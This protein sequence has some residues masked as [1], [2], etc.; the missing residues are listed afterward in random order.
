MSGKRDREIERIRTRS[1]VDAFAPE[2]DGLAAEGGRGHS[3]L[4][5]L[6]QL[7]CALHLICICSYRLYAQNDDEGADLDRNEHES[8]WFTELD[9]ALQIEIT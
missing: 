4:S 6:M 5:K 2:G 1:R 3:S 8:V 9:N 7:H